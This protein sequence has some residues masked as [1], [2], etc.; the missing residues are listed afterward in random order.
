MIG[1]WNSGK[2][3]LMSAVA[4]VFGN[5]VDTRKPANNLLGNDINNDEAK[6]FMWLAD[7]FIRGAR[8]L[9]TNEVRTMSTRGRRTSTAI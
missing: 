5:L 8:L 7:A 4:A 2:G 6:Q 9:R 3:M 1:Q